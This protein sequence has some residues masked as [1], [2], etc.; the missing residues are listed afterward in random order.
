VGVLWITGGLM[1]DIPHCEH[2][3]AFL[4]M[5]LGSDAWILTIFKIQGTKKLVA[6]NLKIFLNTGKPCGVKGTLDILKINEAVE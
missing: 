2:T 6:T 4:T 3:T 5:N 1:W